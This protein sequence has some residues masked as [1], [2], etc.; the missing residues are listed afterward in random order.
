MGSGESADYEMGTGNTW[1]H[2]YLSCY[3]AFSTKGPCYLWGGNDERNGTLFGGDDAI[4]D[5]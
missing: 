2:P 5:S 3:G 4:D 1:I